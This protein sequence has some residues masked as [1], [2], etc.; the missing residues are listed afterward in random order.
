MGERVRK[1]VCVC[2]CVCVCVGMWVCVCVCVCVINILSMI[3]H[4]TTTGSFHLTKHRHVVK[5]TTDGD[6]CCLCQITT[7][8]DY[9]ENVLNN[10]KINC[11]F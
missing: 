3:C 5:W 9:A 2:V 10:W 11:S 6:Q 8:S 1:S 7:L 4:I